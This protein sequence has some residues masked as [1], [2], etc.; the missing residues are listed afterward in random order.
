MDDKI[1]I[2]GVL[3]AIVLSILFFESMRRKGQRLKRK[4]K[5]ERRHA[6]KRDAAWEEKASQ[7]RYERLM[8][9]PEGRLELAGEIIENRE[10]VHTVD[11]I[12]DALDGDIDLELREDLVAVGVPARRVVFANVQ[13]DSS[14]LRFEHGGNKYEFGAI[15]SFRNSSVRVNDQTVLELRD[16]EYVEA[17]IDGDW[18]TDLEE[19][20]DCLSNEVSLELSLRKKEDD[21][22]QERE[23][24]ERRAGQ[25][26]VRPPD[27]KRDE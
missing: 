22:R 3:A 18:I 2:V 5:Q 12:R 23:D 11:C 26:V 17:F 13:N 14:I 6:L 20:A 8:Q 27:Q 15:G 19:M 25:I 24:L 21:E 9:T 7:D 1:V 4:E 16:D 10:I